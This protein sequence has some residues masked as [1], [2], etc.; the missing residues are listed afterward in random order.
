MAVSIRLSRGGSKKRPYYR[1][2]VADARNPRDGKFIEKI[3]TYNPL[4]AKDD[5]KR[6]VLDTER[7]NYWLGVGAQPTDRVARFLD[8]TGVRE[9]AARNNPNKG[10]PGE[11]ATERLEER[12]KK[13]D[14]AEAAKVAAA[15]AEEEAKA[16]AAAAEAE[17]VMAAEVEAAT[18]TPTPEA[19]AVAEATAE[20]T[21]ANG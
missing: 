7:A 17:A 18:E 2:V 8:V 6:I 10:K 14:D 13:L 16:A 1:I 20:E 4:L 5:E 9:R 21:P 15:A 12:Q 3:G 11:K 19:E